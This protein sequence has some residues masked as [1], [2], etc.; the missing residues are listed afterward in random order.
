MKV[1]RVVL[2]SLC[3]P[4]LCRGFVIVSLGGLND[5]ELFPSSDGSRYTSD[6]GSAIS[7][8]AANYESGVS[9]GVRVACVWGGV[10]SSPLWLVVVGRG[11]TA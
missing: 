8:V 4:L 6:I 7:S 10:A 1:E 5:F 11:A 9:I 3:L 2:I